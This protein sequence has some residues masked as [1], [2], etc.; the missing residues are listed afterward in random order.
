MRALAPLATAPRLI[1]YKH[2]LCGSGDQPMR[3]PL[4]AALLES[5]DARGRIYTMQARNDR[6][7][8]R[9]SPES[10]A[11]SFATLPLLCPLLVLSRPAHRDRFHSV[12][13][14]FPGRE[15]DKRVPSTVPGIPASQ[16]ALQPGG[17]PPQ[18]ARMPL[19]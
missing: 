5:R 2:P 14:H 11:Y 15:P 1:S 13:Q 10:T 4:R 12:P 16:L 8:H 3:M 17:L 19:G 9:A 7:P 18:P 6:S